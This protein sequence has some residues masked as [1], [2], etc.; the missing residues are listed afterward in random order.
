MKFEHPPSDGPTFA[1]IAEAHDAARAAH[2]AAYAEW[3]YT[4]RLTD[5]IARDLKRQ[6]LR[7]FGYTDEQIAAI[8]AQIDADMGKR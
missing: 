3:R 8:E 4:E 1:E 5:A 6:M 7:A 2:R